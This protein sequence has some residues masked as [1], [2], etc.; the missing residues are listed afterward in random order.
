MNDQ[1]LVEEGYGLGAVVT[2]I[3]AVNGLDTPDNHQ[4]AVKQLGVADLLL[5]R[6][7]P[8]GLNL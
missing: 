3:D 5:L 2:T 6:G 7:F 8:P 4:E 1:S